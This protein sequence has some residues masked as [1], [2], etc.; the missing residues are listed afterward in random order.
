MTPD[1]FAIVSVVTWFLHRYFFFF[2]LSASLQVTHLL[3]DG[4]RTLHRN[5]FGFQP[6]TW[7]GASIVAFVHPEV[8]RR[9]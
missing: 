9:S 6:S 3:M 5:L 1:F 8:W 7:P 4:G 2:V